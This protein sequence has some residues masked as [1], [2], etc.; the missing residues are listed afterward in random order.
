MSV[1]EE[2]V[3]L[4]PD[5]EGKDGNYA[6]LLSRCSTW[7][8]EVERVRSLSE[9]TRPA[10]R[11]DCILLLFPV[12]R[13]VS[14]QSEELCAAVDVGAGLLIAADHTNAKE[15]RDHLR[16]LLGRF[17]LGV[18]FDS[19]LPTG[20]RTSIQLQ[21]HPLATAWSKGVV[22]R[23][24][25]GASVQVSSRGSVLATGRYYFA[26]Q[27]DVDGIPGNFMGDRQLGGG[28]RI[29]DVVL[30]AQVEFGEGRVLLLGDPTPLL[31]EALPLTWMGVR[32]TLAYLCSGSRGSC[33]GALLWIAAVLIGVVG[34]LV[35]K[36]ANAE[37]GRV[38]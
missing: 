9:L 14:R 34:V 33:G 19:A 23:Y 8:F 12:G 20:G 16:P 3:A 15:T 29:G 30:A 35:L 7:G 22:E 31:P 25:V 17:G 26:D 1:R 36:Q 10:G 5:T 27:G 28:E 21:R 4:Q 13:G 6:Q 2:V 32:D 24:G 11:G 37:G 38:A 18:G